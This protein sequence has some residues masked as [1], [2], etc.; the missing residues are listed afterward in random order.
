MNDIS[1]LNFIGISANDVLLS[2]IFSHWVVAFIRM[3]IAITC[4]TDHKVIRIL[5]GTI[6][7]RPYS[8][9]LSCHSQSGL[10]TPPL[11]S[12]RGQSAIMRSV[13]AWWNG[14]TVFCVCG[15]S[16]VPLFLPF[17]AEIVSVTDAYT[18]VC[19]TIGQLRAVPHKHAHTVPRLKMFPSDG[20]VL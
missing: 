13:L 7:C 17:W 20:N 16:I 3:A 10:P 15:Y 14:I 1:R 8:K 12:E 9:S 6:P 19:V 18:I 11:V 5:T 4:S 2:Q